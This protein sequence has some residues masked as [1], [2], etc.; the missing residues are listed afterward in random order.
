MNVSTSIITGVVSGIIT[1]LVLFCLAK[2]FRNLVLPWYQSLI[3]QGKKINGTWT[4]YRAEVQN[5]RYIADDLS[6]STI[7]LKQKANKITGEILVT[8]QISGK[9][10]RKIF[11]IKGSF[12]DN[13]L[14][15]NLKVKDRSRMGGGTYIMCLAEDGQKMKG[16]H[17]YVSSHDA[18]S[19]FAKDEVWIR[20]NQ[21]GDKTID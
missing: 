2:V 5:G 13:V 11:I 16:K 20:S 3:Y 19:I 7:N 4:G 6:R 14:I 12:K 8:R 1:Y 18:K 10:C 15:I 21:S 9:D 17:T